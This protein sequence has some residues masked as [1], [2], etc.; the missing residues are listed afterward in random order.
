MTIT[1]D[2]K[3]IHLG[4]QVAASILISVSGFMWWGGSFTSGYLQKQDYIYKVIVVLSKDNTG[5][6]NV[7]AQNT[8]DIDSLK[9]VIKPVE[10]ASIDNPDHFYIEIKKNGH[11]YYKEV[12]K[13]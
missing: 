12:P 11:T 9:K 7:L 2:K 6:K 3:Q 10:Y 1:L 4:W 5:I 8:R 13:P